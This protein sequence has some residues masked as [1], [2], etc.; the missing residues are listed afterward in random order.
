[1]KGYD[2]IKFFETSYEY[3]G[4]HREDTEY[5]FRVWAQD[6][7]TVYVVG[8]FNGWDESC[9]MALIGD[10]IWECKV[11]SQNIREGDLYKYKIKNGSQELYKADPYSFRTKGDNETASVIFD[12]SGYPWRDKGWLEYRRNKANNEPVNI[13]KIHASSWKR[14]ENGDMYSWH[15]L[16]TELA[17]YVKQ[18]GYTHVELMPIM[19]HRTESE[20]E[21]RIDSYYAPI[22][23]MGNPCEFMSF[24]DSM[25]EAGI[26]VI[27]DW[28][29]AYFSKN[30]HS[31][32][33]FDG[34]TLYEYE[35]ENKRENILNGTRFFDLGRKEVKSFLISNAHFW[36]NVY[37]ADGLRLDSTSIKIFSES[38]E[39]ITFFH[40][41]ASSVKKHFSD[42]LIIDTN[43]RTFLENFN[44]GCDR[45]ADIIKLSLGYQ[46]TFPCTKALFMGTELGQ[47]W[48]S[49]RTLTVTWSLLECETNVKLQYYVAELNHFYLK[50]SP[51]WCEEGFEMIDAN[52]SD[53][54][55][56]R[57]IDC[58]GNE[59]IIILNLTSAIKQDFTIGVSKKG[60]YEKIFNSDDRRFGGDGKLNSEVI[61]SEN[62]N[63]SETIKL[64]VPP[65]SFTVWRCVEQSY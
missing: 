25:H 52:D 13:Y 58:N 63:C 24:V 22:A 16:A 57:R 23:C 6:A 47:C 51:L 48:E 4:V 3:L 55:S 53:I 37:H 30:E 59:L 39:G 31:L 14:H 60:A 27:L 38:D 19:D 62:I 20:F 18:M 46:I 65:M 64:D 5:I 50:A 15:E 35:D 9:P 12:I 40:E 2:N 56:Y 1:M 61:E 32:V 45:K 54:I 33:D 21:Y 44:V 42:V 34:Q 26:G 7:D 49:E 28:I 43:E 10:G 8:D 11:L 17:P 36:L 29:P 41:L